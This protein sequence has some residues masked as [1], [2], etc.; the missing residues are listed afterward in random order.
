MRD[1]RFRLCNHNLD[2]WKEITFTRA[3]GVVRYIEA[4][5][6]L[7]YEIEWKTPLTGEYVTLIEVKD[8]VRTYTNPNFK[9][10][11]TFDKLGDQV[12]KE[13]APDSPA[14]LIY[15]PGL[16]LERSDFKTNLAYYRND[17][18]ITQAALA[19]RSGVSLRTIQEYEQGRKPINGAAAL[20]VYRLAQAIGVTVEDLL[21]LDQA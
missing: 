7:T 12:L 16:K 10:P 14:R 13:D 11:K 21:D 3:T 17:K 1:F 4:N 9:I 6:M 8:G 18:R 20:T 15:M 5:N 2:D 19:E